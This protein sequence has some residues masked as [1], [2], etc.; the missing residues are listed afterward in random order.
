M[1]Y[2]LD[3][4]KRSK[5]TEDIAKVSSALSKMAA[6][7]SVGCLPLFLVFIASTSAQ[8]GG[9]GKLE[10]RQEDEVQALQAHY[11][12][13]QRWLGNCCRNE[14]QTTATPPGPSCWY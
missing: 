1:N 6:A 3:K 2:R 8:V 13:C 7:T 10:T 9:L 14:R 5:V 11:C 12:G 4:K